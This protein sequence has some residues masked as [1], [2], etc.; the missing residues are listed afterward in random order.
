LLAIALTQRPELGE[1]QAAI[2]AALLALQGAR[3]LPFSPDV[4]VGYSAGTFGGGSNLAAAGILQ[5]DGTVLQQNRFGNFADRQDFDAVVYWSLQNLGVGNLALVR[6]AQSHL[7]AEDLRRVAVL[8]RVRAEVATAYAG[9]HARFAQIEI[10][11]RAVGPSKDAFDED[12]RRILAK[13]GLPI[14]LLDSLRLLGQSRNAYLDAIVDYNEAQ[15][16]LYVALG[17]P[18]ANR[19]A[20]PIP[21]SLVAP[22]QTPGPGK[23]EPAEGAGMK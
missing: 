4:T 13:Q 7:R 20:R 10:A 1:R 2:R 6:L 15:F 8:D 17:Q 12:L 14:E 16:A 3:V 23:S 5:A 19:L 11:E 21:A 18:P 9:T 22:P